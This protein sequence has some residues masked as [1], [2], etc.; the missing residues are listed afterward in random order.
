MI[1]TSWNFNFA[2]VFHLDIPVMDSRFF[3]IVP[4]PSVLYNQVL[5]CVPWVA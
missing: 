1:V 3:F 5:R 4:T 2:S